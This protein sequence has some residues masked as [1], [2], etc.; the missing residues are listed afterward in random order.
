MDNVQL[1][2]HHLRR[3]RAHPLILSTILPAEAMPHPLILSTTSPAVN[4]GYLNLAAEAGLDP[5]RDGSSYIYGL[6]RRRYGYG[7]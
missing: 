6:S 4:E 5:E 7:W 1:R 2:K 3:A